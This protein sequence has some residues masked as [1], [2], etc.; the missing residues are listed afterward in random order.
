MVDKSCTHKPVHSVHPLDV[1]QVDKDYLVLAEVQVNVSNDKLVKSRHCG[2]RLFHTKSK[3]QIGGLDFELERLPSE[4]LDN[5]HD[6][7]RIYNFHANRDTRNP[8]SKA[9]ITK[10]E[11]IML[12]AIMQLYHPSLKIGVE[13]WFTYTGTASGPKSMKAFAK[14]HNK[15]YDYK[16]GMV[17]IREAHR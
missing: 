10:Y 5:S 17:I 14:N 4:C 7:V 16:M 9:D 12:E 3:Q 11:K 2:L 6:M 13:T 8:K 1:L 15:V